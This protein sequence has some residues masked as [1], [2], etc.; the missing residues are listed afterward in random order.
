MPMMMNPDMPPDLLAAAQATD[1]AVGDELAALIPPP[2]SPYN[3]KV[4][5]ALARAIAEAA[6]VMDMDLEPIEYNEPAARLDPEVVR[7]L[8]MLAAA[9]KDYGQPFPVELEAIKGDGELTAITAHLM[10][11]AADDGF[12]KFLDQPAEAVQID[13]T[14]GPAED[15]EEFDFASRMARR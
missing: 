1:D 11:L 3:A 10:K 9:A 12:R 4:L 13:I 15:A 14:A 5:T 7:M 8:A 2:A 6:K